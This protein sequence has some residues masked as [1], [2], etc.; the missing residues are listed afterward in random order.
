MLLYQ[1]LNRYRTHLSRLSTEP[2]QVLT[3]PWKHHLNSQRS[4]QLWPSNHWGTW[5]DPS[6]CH[7]QLT[8]SR[9]RVGHLESAHHHICET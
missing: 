5:P 1:I 6:F 2:L 7:P 9:P 3:L 4:L 8:G